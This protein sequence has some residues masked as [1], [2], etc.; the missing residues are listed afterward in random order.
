MPT[1]LPISS[2]QPS[3]VWVSLKAY[4]QAR[5]AI[6]RTGVS[7][8][9][10]ENLQFKLSHAYA[11]D[12]VYASVDLIALLNQL[13]TFN[14][15]VI[16]LQSQCSNRVTYLQRPDWGRK[17]NVESINKLTANSTPECDIAIVIADGLSAFAVNEHVIPLLKLI[18]PL[19]TKNHFSIAPI[20]IVEQ[21]RVAIADEVGSLLKAKLT[22]I[23]IGERPGLT[24]PNSLGAYITYNPS[25][26][27]TDERRNCISNI[28]PEGLDYQ[29]AAKKIINLVIQALQLKLSGVTL[30]EDATLTE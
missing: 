30:K 27:L 2:Q 22:L 29:A 18:I 5:I 12:A 17:L 6:G 7:I 19:L 23:L 11:K 1:N 10:Q 9:L 24:S 21:G 16:Q 25:V 13:L 20:I 4:T 3:D 8:P 15:P 14:L 28:R 26:G